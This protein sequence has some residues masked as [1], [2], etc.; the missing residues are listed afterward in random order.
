MKR[1]LI[2]AVVGLALMVGVTACN[3]EDMSK[4][5][6]QRYF[7]EQYDKALSVASCESG[8]NPAAVSPGGGNWGLFQINLVHAD[9]VGSLGYTWDQ[10]L[11][12]VANAHV[13]RVI[14]DSGG[15]WGAWS[16]G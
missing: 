10:M 14:Y 16:C 4:A 1:L 2:S 3:T 8:L 5:A 12:P 9:L 15:G 6:I 11:N 13:A 7:P